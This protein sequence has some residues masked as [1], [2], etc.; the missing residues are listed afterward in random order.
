MSMHTSLCTQR[1]ILTSLPTHSEI[2]PEQDATQEFGSR[3]ACKGTEHFCSEKNEKD[4][5]EDSEEQGQG[6]GQ[7]SSTQANA[8]ARRRWIEKALERAYQRLAAAAHAHGS[9]SRESIQTHVYRER[10]QAHFYRQRIRTL[11]DRERTHFY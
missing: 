5:I 8:F 10:I 2:C 9:S 7:G 6:R 3:G 1:T 4:G 11:S